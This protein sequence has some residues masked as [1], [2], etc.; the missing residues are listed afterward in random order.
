MYNYNKKLAFTEP[1][2]CAKNWLLQVLFHLTLTAKKGNWGLEELG[3]LPKA[4]APVSKLVRIQ[5]EIWL[6]HHAVSSRAVH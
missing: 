6:K 5:M 4:I 3:K 1:L 2:S